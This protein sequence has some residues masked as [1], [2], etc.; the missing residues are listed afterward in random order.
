MIW[1]TLPLVTVVQRCM[2]S[3]SVLR[4]V[5]NSSQDAYN[6]AITPPNSKDQLDLLRS[7]LNRQLTVHAQDFINSWKSEGAF[8]FTTKIP[9]GFFLPDLALL[10]ASTEILTPD[11]RWGIHVSFSVLENC[12]WPERFS[13]EMSELCLAST[14]WVVPR[15]VDTDK[16]SSSLTRSAPLPTEPVTWILTTPTV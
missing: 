6:S 13:P 7:V 9:S 2:A 14:L 1:L 10:F 16:G 4:L 3:S 12:P 8:Q 11:S 15:C 5:F